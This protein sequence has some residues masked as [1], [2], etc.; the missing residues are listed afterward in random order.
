M[1]NLEEMLETVNALAQKVTDLKKAVPVDKDAIGKTVKE[2]LDAKRSY[3]ENNNGIGVDGKPWEEPM[4]K[5]E[6]KKKEKAEKAAKAAVTV[7]GKQASDPDSAGAKKKAAKKADKSQTKAAAKGGAPAAKA[8]AVPRAAAPKKI[9]IASRSKLRA[10]Q[11]SFNPNAPL[12]ERPVIALTIA[13]LSNTTNDY[14]IV[15]DHTRHSAALGLPDG[16]GELAGDAA[17]ARYIARKSQSTIGNALIGGDFEQAA[18]IDSWI[19]YANSLS[20]FQHIRRVKAVSSTLDRVLKEKTYIVGHTMTIADIALFATMGFPSQATDVA[21]VEAII[22]SPSTPTMRWLKMMKSCPAVR[23][24]TQLALGIS[25]VEAVFDP[26]STM[27][28]LVSGMN[29]LEGATMGNVVTRFP[30]EPSGYLHI[31]HAKAVLMNEYFARRYKGRLIVRFDDTNPSKEKEEF[32]TAILEDL[33]MLGVKPD[34]VTFT[35]DYFETIRGYANFLIENRLAFM[36]DT[37]QEEMQKE[38]MDRVNSRHREQSIEDCKNYFK[39][40]C[41]GDEDGGKWCLRAKID[42]S[43]D[44]GTMRDPVLYR[45]NV[46]PHHRSGTKYKAYPTYD[47]ACP[48]VD[49]IEGVTHALRTTEYNDRDEQYQWIQSAFNLRRTRI[50]SFSRLNFMYT[51][52]SK[53]KLTWFVENNHVTGWDDPRFPTIRGVLRRGV[54]FKSLRTFILSQGAS[55]RVV[56]MEWSK[57]WAENKKEIDVRA[58]RFMAI[59]KTNN[60]KLTVTNAPTADDNAYISTDYMPKDPSFGKR[61]IRITKNVLLESADTDG[62]SEGENIVLMRWG[63]IKINKID[64][65]NFEGEFIPDG[66]FKAAKRKLSWMADVGETLPVTLHEFDNLISKAKL[67]EDEDFK[68]FINPNTLACT[69]VIGDAG[70]QTLQ[71]NDII[72]LERRGYYKVEQP[73]MSAEKGLQL[74]MVPDGK[75]K[76][77]G[78]ITG[79]LAHR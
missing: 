60:V 5:S 6:K 71:K 12:T 27:D 61:H 79:K 16:R 15:S 72:Q 73:Y 56:N 40:M 23:E 67:E 75:S 77:M 76:S 30:P 74:F 13:C 9:I 47:L 49:S 48:I 68:D 37:P 51:E 29:A 1:A 55:R 57:F 45:Q 35:S 39:Q 53:R 24:A 64:G 10:M 65:S 4:S 2:L 43:S 41:S 17:I 33:D 31:G 44:N 8:N 14:S 19:D 42:M 69:E 25:N 26:N 18:I 62:I 70:L 63:V 21:Q 22:G 59:D 3:A 7:N 34:V 66:D 38:R 28:P 58:K 20:K 52:L 36:D 54:D 32:Q 50:H 78:G 46:L 11:I